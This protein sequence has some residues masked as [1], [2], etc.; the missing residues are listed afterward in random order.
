MTDY[1]QGQ[2]VST[3]KLDTTR[4]RWLPLPAVTLPDGELP[5]YPVLSYVAG[6]FHLEVS[7]QHRTTNTLGQLTISGGAD[8]WVL[9]SD[10]WTPE[11][12]DLPA[13]S[14]GGTGL[15][16]GGKVVRIG[17][18]TCPPGTPCGPPG[19]LS[20]SPLDLG[21]LTAPAPPF[22]VGLTTSTGT[23]LVTFSSS[24]QRAH[25]QVVLELGDAAAYDL[26]ADQWVRLPSAHRVVPTIQ[27]AVWTGATLLLY[28]DGKVATLTP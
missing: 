17:T 7:W 1:E 26:G 5:S 14:R 19:I 8:H 21:T 18:E 11:S 9:D 12:T 25:G 28:G 3:W 10:T 15:E 23:T 4:S 20:P 16:L 27:T 13:T 6:A 24:E 22:P 2:S